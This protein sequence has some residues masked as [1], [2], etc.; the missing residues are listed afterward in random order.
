MAYLCFFIISNLGFTFAFWASSISGSSTI[1]SVN[2]NIGTF[3]PTGF[4]GVSQNGSLDN[5]EWISFDQIQPNGNYV[6]MT[7]IN[8]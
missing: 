6:Q 5:V 1:T 8:F 7:D 3:V 4:T 2:I